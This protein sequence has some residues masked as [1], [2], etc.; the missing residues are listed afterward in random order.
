[1]CLFQKSCVDTLAFLDQGSMTTL[2][3]GRLLES[4]RISEE[5]TSYSITTVNQTSEQRNGQKAK[6]LISAVT[7]NAIIELINVYC[8][9]KLPIRPNPKLTE[10]DLTRWP[11]LQEL[12][13]PAV[14]PQEVQLLIGVDNPEVFWTLDERHR[15]KGGPFAVRIMLGWLLLG[16]T[17]GKS[18]HNLKVNFVR[19]TND[20][21][22]KQVEC[23]WK[24]DNMPTSSWLGVGMSK[25]D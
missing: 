1:M 23:L 10:D 14:R 4:L 13:L 3:D 11:H 20:L 5:K 22:Q 24:L 19:K 12:E 7:S 17:V 2:C 21:L 18:N 6:L 25:N 8:V 16:G 9:D 15:R